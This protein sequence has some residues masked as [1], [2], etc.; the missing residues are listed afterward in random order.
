MLHSLEILSDDR[1]TEAGLPRP[2]VER[3][4]QEVLSQIV[5]QVVTKVQELQSWI[6]NSTVNM[7]YEYFPRL[8]G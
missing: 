4:G 2:V 7:A 5:V 6:N 3:G 1:E 8:L